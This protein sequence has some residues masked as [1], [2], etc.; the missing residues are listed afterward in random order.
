LISN[1]KGNIELF[2]TV[3]NFYLLSSN[4]HFCRERAFIPATNTTISST[5]MAETP[6]PAALADGET[7]PST[8][9]SSTSASDLSHSRGANLVNES[10]IAIA[11][12]EQESSSSKKTPSSSSAL[13]SK[14]NQLIEEFIDNND[15]SDDEDDD[16]DDSDDDSEYEDIDDE[17]FDD[18][19]DSDDEDN[20]GDSQRKKR[21][22][23]DDENKDT[24][25]YCDDNEEDMSYEESSFSDDG[26]SISANIDITIPMPSFKTDNTEEYVKKLIAL[27]DYEADRDISF[28]N[29]V[30]RAENQKQKETSDEYQRDCKEVYKYLVGIDEA[31]DPFD[32]QYNA[33]CRDP[34]HSMDKTCAGIYVE[35]SSDG[36]G[37]KSG[38]TG[39]AKQRKDYR[40]KSWEKQGRPAP[41]MCLVVNID[42]L[43]IEAQTKVSEMILDIAKKFMYSEK[44]RTIE[45]ALVCDKNGLSFAVQDFFYHLV[46]GNAIRVNGYLRRCWLMI[47]ESGFQ[48][49]CQEKGFPLLQSSCMN[50]QV[51]GN[52]MARYLAMNDKVQQD[53]DKFLKRI[54]KSL[55]DV[56]DVKGVMLAWKP[57]QLPSQGSEFQYAKGVV[58]RAV[59]GKKCTIENAFVGPPMEN[60][61]TMMSIAFNESLNK[62]CT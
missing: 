19:D 4:A 35:E 34:K 15:D 53:V 2:F 8:R 43:S 56:T 48:A 55:P 21:K 14:N 52:G 62:S 18:D 28:G 1:I 42:S 22:R 38:S 31:L 3:Q 45:D 54:K 5:T 17:I 20:V 27:Y 59:F 26:N 61:L 47:L 13:L 32:S 6:L 60:P 44:P 58:A 39:D 51:N 41:E 37:C 24:Q 50:E 57:G 23:D 36:S 7:P 33:K 16:D 25:C 49:Y 11:R 30:R 9:H 10:S 29:M 46:E 40:K 12:Q